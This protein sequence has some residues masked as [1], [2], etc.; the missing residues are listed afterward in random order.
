MPTHNDEDHYQQLDERMRDFLRINVLPAFALNGNAI[1]AKQMSLISNLER[2]GRRTR[3]KESL[4]RCE[5]GRCGRT[6]CSGS[7][8]LGGREVER[9]RVV[10]A[11]DLLSTLDLPAYTATLIFPDLDLS[12][13]DL[14][15]FNPNRIGQRLKRMYQV[16]NKLDYTLHAFGGIEASLERD[17]EGRLFWRVHCH[18]VVFTD[19]PRKLLKKLLRPRGSCP[20]GMRPL[21]I[22]EVTNLGN[23]LSYSLKPEP[24]QRRSGIGR[25]NEPDKRSD[26]LLTGRERVIYELW[27]HRGGPQRLMLRGLKVVHGKLCLTKS[28]QKA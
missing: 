24:K 19:C 6:T 20:S 11:Y 26:P 9:Q 2:T 14:K 17:A 15:L 8:W 27:M 28:K 7:C 5:P 16:I 21:R 12:I 25:R 10:E 23:A 3:L 22:D 4:Q 18:L 13:K 1:A